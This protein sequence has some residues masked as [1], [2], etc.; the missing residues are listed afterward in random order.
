MA[1]EPA[2]QRGNPQPLG[3]AWR[4]RSANHHASRL[5]A[6]IQKAAKTGTG[7]ATV[8]RIHSPGEGESPTRDSRG[9]CEALT[10]V[11]LASN[12]LLDPRGTLKI[13]KKP[14]KTQGSPGEEQK[15]KTG[16]ERQTLEE[17][18]TEEAMKKKR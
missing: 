7:A 11:I 16:Q 15:R 4:P 9:R 2:L 3:L 12:P 18:E 14:L 10:R 8:S 6:N 17:G 5:L 1:L 13:L